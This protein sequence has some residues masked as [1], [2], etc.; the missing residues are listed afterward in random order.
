MINKIISLGISRREAEELIAVSKDIEHD[1]ELLK[2][3]YPIQYLIGYVDFYGYRINVSE[4]T[5]IP[6]YE[7]EYLVEKVINI[8]N[9]MFNDKIN[10]LDIGTGSGAISIVLKDKLNSMVTG[11]DIS[12][13]AL[14]MAL[15]NAK[16]NNLDIN[17]VKSDIFSNI[18][19]KF[20]VIVS[21]P[22]YISRNEVIMDSVKKY[23][24]NIAL[25]ADNEGLY[26]YE[27]IIK[28]AKKFLNDK[29]LIAF[30][31]GWWQGNLIYDIAKSYFNDSVIKIEK[32]LTGRDRYL[33]IINE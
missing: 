11:C 26:F 27:I 12:D 30:E 29:F 14:K 25:Y 15:N 5:L 19:G 31:I 20:D 18:N 10:I 1:Y 32:D 17:Y 28:N 3:G 6:R 8:C 16:I 7:T 24:P 33:F 13:K 4:D 9:K 23:E 2:N 22:P 21:N